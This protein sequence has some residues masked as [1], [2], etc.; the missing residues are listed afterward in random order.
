MSEARPSPAGQTIGA[1]A[2]A[3]LLRMSPNELTKLAGDGVI[4]RVGP[5]AYHPGAIISAYIE[6]LR[7]EPERR[8]RALPTQPEIAAHLDISDRRLRELLTEW[9]IDHKQ[10]TL[11][12]LR[13]RYIRKL[14]EEAAGR[15]SQDPDG[16][17]LVQERAALAREMRM[18]HEIKNEVARKTYGPITL[19]AETL[20][21][22]S[23]AVVEQFEQLP[24]ALK[25]AC[26]DLPE[27]ARDKVM[28]V[29]AAARNEWVERT[30]QMVTEQV[31]AALA[32]DEPLEEAQDA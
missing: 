1:D 6:H 3:K 9:G 32:E 19:L 22:A 29:I 4:P 25:K 12:E 21:A 24:S 8:A 20:A 18:G 27:A 17:D 15:S 13:V 14:R 23:Q 28:A 7:G 2:A 26:P 31:A 16:L 10:T 30:R 11:A 5:G